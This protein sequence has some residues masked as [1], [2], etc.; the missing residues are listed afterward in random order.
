[1]QRIKDIEQEAE[2][3]I[4]TMKEAVESEIDDFRQ[5]LEVN[6]CPVRH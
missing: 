4:R 1:M 2:D 3:E 6:C 5:K